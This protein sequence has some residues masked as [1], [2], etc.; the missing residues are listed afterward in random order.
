MEL[1]E[2]RSLIS[3]A[4]RDESTCF[5]DGA[6]GHHVLDLVSLEVADEVPTNAIEVCESLGFFFELLGIIFAEVSLPGLV[7]GD[8]GLLGMNLGDGHQ[9]DFARGTPRAGGGVRDL[10]FYLPEVLCNISHDSG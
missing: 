7:G 2:A 10:F 4:R 9:S 5:D 8:D 3:S 1:F 6:G